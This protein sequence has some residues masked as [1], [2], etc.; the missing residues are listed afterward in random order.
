M[1]TAW[2]TGKDKGEAANIEASFKSC[3]IMRERLRELCEKEIKNSYNLSKDQYDSPNW[4]MLQADAIGYK[5]AMEKI[6]SLI[7]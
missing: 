6:I 7:S 3:S 2:V 5:R 1:K 4:Q